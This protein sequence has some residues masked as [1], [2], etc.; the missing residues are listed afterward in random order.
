MA[1]ELQFVAQLAEVLDDAIMNDS[2]SCICMR[3][4]IGFRR[5]AMRGPP[6]MAYADPSRQRLGGEARL[7][8]F[9]LA[10]GPAT[11]QPATFERGNAGRVIAAIFEPPQSFEE[12]SGNR[13]VP[14]H[15]DNSAHGLP[16]FLIAPENRE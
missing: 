11:R 7:E 10:F 1:F 2:N 12:R 8:V 14:D 16:L 5:P 13:A 15:A 4:R 6:C 3:M 9:E